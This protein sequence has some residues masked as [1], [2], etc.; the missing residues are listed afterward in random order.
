MAL[1]TLLLVGGDS[2]DHVRAAIRLLVRRAAQ[3]Q[4]NGAARPA[5]RGHGK[6]PLEMLAEAVTDFLLKGRFTG[7]PALSEARKVV[8]STYHDRLDKGHGT[9]S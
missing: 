7:I 9:I 6:R 3:Q 8:Q 5:T 2:P 4:G 1:P